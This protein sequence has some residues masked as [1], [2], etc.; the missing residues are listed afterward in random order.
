MPTIR[1]IEKMADAA[2]AEQERVEIGEKR[3]CYGLTYEEGVR[4]ALQWASGR[5]DDLPVDGGA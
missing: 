2:C 1:D 5:C 3:G 4:D